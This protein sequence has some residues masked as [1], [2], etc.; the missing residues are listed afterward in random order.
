M[1][2]YWTFT[3]PESFVRFTEPSHTQLTQHTTN[4]HV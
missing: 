4:K 3:F 2:I 1:H